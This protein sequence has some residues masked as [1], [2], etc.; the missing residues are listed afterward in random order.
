MAGQNFAH[1]MIESSTFILFPALFC[2]PPAPDENIYFFSFYCLRWL[3]EVWCWTE[4]KSKQV[5]GVGVSEL[6]DKEI[7]KS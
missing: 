4:L 7:C 5:E 1:V 3:V 6:K 2:S